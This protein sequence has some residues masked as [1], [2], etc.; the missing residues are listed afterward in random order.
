MRRL[1]LLAV[2]V[3][4]GCAPS[5]PPRTEAP[6]TMAIVN[7]RVWTG[8]PERPSAEAV[9]ISGDRIAAVGTSDEVRQLVAGS[10]TVGTALEIID[11]GGQ[12]LVPGFID[13]H[14]HFLDGGQRLASVQLRDAKTRDEFVARIA[15]FAKTVPAGTWIT[16]GDWDHQL[17]GGELP[18]REWIDAVTP[19]HPVWVNRLDGH[20]ALA[21]SAA[22]A[23][24]GVT[25]AAP[26][27]SG[28]RDRKRCGRRADRAAEGQ[29]HGSRGGEDAAAAAEM[30]GP[31]TRR[32]HAYVAEQGVTSVHHM[33][34]LGRAR[35]PRPRVPR[36]GRLR[37]RIYA[38][39]PLN[40]WQ[41]LA[42][43]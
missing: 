31:R 6:V 37:T 27:V 16:G 38:A 8:D 17:W 42:T 18:R 4:A 30:R 12:F 24:A 40:T 14:V 20:M 34:S 33:G 22:L 2:L 28:R 7:A 10:D 21:N 13:S 43:R 1:T 11:A 3:V 39:V 19:D 23:A 9:A 15:A 41:R 35:R 26:D 25:R 5:A 36:R 32:R 29:R